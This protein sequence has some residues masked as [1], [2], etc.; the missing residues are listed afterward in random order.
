VSIKCPSKH[1]YLDFQRSCT[2]LNIFNQF[3]LQRQ[4]EAI[5]TPLWFII[6]RLL[7]PLTLWSNVEKSTISTNQI[8]KN[9]EFNL[10]TLHTKG[11]S[12]KVIVLHSINFWDEFWPKRQTFEGSLGWIGIETKLCPRGH[13]FFSLKS[14]KCI[15]LTISS[16]FLW[17]LIK[18]WPLNPTTS[19]LGRPEC[20]AALIEL[21]LKSKLRVH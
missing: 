8:A 2:L 6:W 3:F 11:Q 10:S 5:F 21:V 13:W 20:E 14:E 9:Q 7:G 17:T 15:L 16:S 4:E 18:V 19:Q 12:P 1:H